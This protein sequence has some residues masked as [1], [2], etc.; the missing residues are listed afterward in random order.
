LHQMG[1][2]KNRQA[3]GDDPERYGGVDHINRR[4]R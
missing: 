2:E 3:C 1:R 4:R